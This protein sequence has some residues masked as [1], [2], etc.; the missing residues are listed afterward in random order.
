[1]AAEEDAGVARAAACLCVLCG[2][3]AAGKSTL[4]R[5]VLST[6]AQHG[7]RVAVVPYDDLIPQHAFQTRAVESEVALQDAVKH[8]ATLKLLSRYF[9]L[10]WNHAVKRSTTGTAVIKVI[11]S[12]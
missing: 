6:A 10:T 12:P 1:M 9:S 7:W 4:A 2:L 5:T 8:H 11:M 3:P